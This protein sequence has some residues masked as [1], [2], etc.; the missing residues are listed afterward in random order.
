MSMPQGPAHALAAMGLGPIGIKKGS[1]LIPVMLMLLTVVLFLAFVMEGSKDE[2]TA[3]FTQAC[4]LA[5]KQADEARVKAAAKPAQ[6]GPTAL[7][8]AAAPDAAKPTYLRDRCIAPESVGGWPPTIAIEFAKFKTLQ[9]M[10]P[11]INVFKLSE[12]GGTAGMLN[13]GKSIVKGYIQGLISAVH[14]HAVDVLKT[15]GRIGL[16]SLIPGIAGLIYRRAFWTWFGISF[17]GLLGV[18]SILKVEPQ[19]AAALTLTDDAL[20][21]TIFLLVVSQVVMMLFAHR[22]RRYSSSMTTWIPPGLYNKVLALVLVGLAIA[23]MFFGLGRDVWPYLGRGSGFLAWLFKWEFILVGLPILYTLLRQSVLWSGA[24]PKNIIVCLDGTSNTPDQYELG[25]LAQ[26]NVFKL[27]QMLKG[28]PMKGAGVSFDASIIKRYDDKQI[29]FYYIGVGNKQENDP[30]AQLLGQGTGL[31]AADIMER[32]YL[33]IMRVYQPGDRVFIFGFSRG[34]AIARLLART[35][36]QRGAPK[37]VWTLRLFGRHWLVWKSKP[38]KR[39]DG[40]V[41]IAV[42]GCWDTVGAFGI[43]KKIG[44][45]DFQKIDMFKDLSVPDNVRQAYHMVALDEQRDSFVP[46]LMDPD[47][48]EP[49]RIVEVWFSGD[50]ANVGGGWA[51][52]RLSDVTLDFLLRHVSSGYA[53]DAKTQPGEEGWGIYL[54]GMRKRDGMEAGINGDGVMVIDPDPLG[55]LRQWTSSLYT[56]EPR[57]LPIH[58]VISETV[59]D[60]MTQSVPVYAPKSLF[61]L[62][63]E[64]DGRRVTVDKAVARLTDTGSLKKEEKEA[65]LVFKDKLR[66]TRWPHHVEALREMGAAPNPE[67][68][69]RN[70][71]AS[72]SAMQGR[73]APDAV[74]EMADAM[75]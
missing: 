72:G 37:S 47:P 16:L 11:E 44:G 6:T 45:I 58:A 19:N 22:L 49:G 61:D 33:D 4:T 40:R 59:F 51:T 39:S 75:T 34:A 25:R 12:V 55:K 52:P 65:I 29:G 74:A 31:G 60:R 62:N 63:E 32:A 8:P 71:V 23:M 64:L 70:G 14:Q 28:K 21:G 1:R 43:A 54:S 69:L 57:K 9:D 35:I 50:H 3:Q 66:L 36:D 30:I 27:F 41:P 53:T 42:L 68:D 26:T 38:D 15:I 73:D 7:A 13:I 56:Y 10:V 2:L 46:T 67:R 5:R 48:I 24:S 18:N 17:V 20:A